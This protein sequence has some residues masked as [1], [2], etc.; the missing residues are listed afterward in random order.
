MVFPHS[1]ENSNVGN[2]LCCR[3]RLN[4]HVA[5]YF[6]RYYLSNRPMEPAVKYYLVP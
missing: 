2:K 4:I 3:S 5:N 1:E 6:Y